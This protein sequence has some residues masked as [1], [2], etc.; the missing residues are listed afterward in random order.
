MA[1]ASNKAVFLD[2]DGTIIRDISYLDDPEQIEFLP[3]AVEALRSLHD[4]EYLLVVITNQSGVARG[5]F[6]EETCRKV[7]HQFTQRLVAQG[8]P[9]GASY[10]CPHLP[11]APVP[12]YDQVC[13]CRKPAKGLFEKA[14]RELDIDFKSSWAVGDSLRDL[15]PGSELG[16]RTVLVLTGKGR[17]QAALEDAGLVADFTAGDLAEAAHIILGI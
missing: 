9:V 7:N 11:G 5:F 8:I 16:A 15:K 17:E 14:A 6:D 12:E 2:R 3:G 13:N 1:F 4:K 10:Y